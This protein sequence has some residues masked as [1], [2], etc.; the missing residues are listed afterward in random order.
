MRLLL[1]HGL[2]LRE[3]YTN[4]PA[5]IIDKNL[6]FFINNVSHVTNREDG[7]AAP[8][9]Y[10]L[11]IIFN[12]MLDEKLRFIVPCRYK[13]YWDFVVTTDKDFEK[14][15]QLGRFSEIDFI[16]SDFT[17]YHLQYFFASKNHGI[18]KYN[19]YLGGE[20]KNKLIEKT[21]NG[22][23][24]YS[25]KDFTIYDILDEVCEKF[26]AF[27]R[28][29]I[30]S[31]LLFGF[32]R[33]NNCIRYGCYLTFSVYGYHNCYAHVGLIYAD[34]RKRLLLHKRVRNKKL[35]RIY[36][37]KKEEFD[38]SYYIWLTDAKFKEWVETN[39]KSK[40]L[41]KFG[42][43]ALKRI[44]EECFYEASI[45]HIFKVNVK[46]RKN[47]KILHNNFI[48]RK[49]TYMGKTNKGTFTKSPEITWKNLIK[50]YETRI[51]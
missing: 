20:L 38:G 39:K 50:E 44:M 12:K 17:G 23:K 37:W 36:S 24:F 46:R 49:T 25:I 41:I 14:Q 19:I 45:V 5:K 32:R 27:T 16:N 15:R 4:T 22:E 7:M 42:K 31:L 1:N 21:N 51:S 2:T 47:W 40:S 48:V 10:A 29:E 34:Q 3:L 8:L 33:M 28:Q 6:T 35:R 9:K 26:P 30:R 43:V 11:G 18:K 13:A